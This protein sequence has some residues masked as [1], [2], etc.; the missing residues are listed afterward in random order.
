MK[1]IAWNLNHRSRVKK[2][3]A[4]TIAFLADYKPD[5]VVLNEFVD[6]PLRKQFHADV[7]AAGYQYSAISKHYPD[8]NQ[9]LILSRVPMIAGDIAPPTTSEAAQSN[10]LHVKLPEHAIEVVGMR[11]PAYKTWSEKSDYWKEV[12]A[13]A[14]RNAGRNII[15]LGDLNYDPFTGISSGVEK[16]SFAL[17]DTYYMPNPKGDWSFM[18]IDGANTSRIDHAIVSS[19]LHVSEVEYMTKWRDIQLAGSRDMSPVTDHAVLS[20]SVALAQ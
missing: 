16:I 13:I 11:A 18:S 1:I 17:S 5:L 12:A 9:I 2:I 19:K 8:N 14:T 10:F 3:P 7:R 15:F 20:L 6:S 4:E